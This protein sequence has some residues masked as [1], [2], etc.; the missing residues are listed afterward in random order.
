MT[1]STFYVSA[2]VSGRFSFPCSEKAHGA[3]LEVPG[4]GIK[5]TFPSLRGAA[6]PG[7]GDYLH[8]VGVLVFVVA[9]VV[10]ALCFVCLQVRRVRRCHNLS[11]GDVHAGLAE[12]V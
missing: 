8:D 1:P 10:F 4:D 3:S 7:G 11:A 5:D 12:V 9:V 6:V 2:M